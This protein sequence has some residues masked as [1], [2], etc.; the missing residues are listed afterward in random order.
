M[1]ANWFTL[2]A[3]TPDNDNASNDGTALRQQLELTGLSYADWELEA[4]ALR[5]AADGS[6]AGGFIDG[7]HL[8]R[9]GELIMLIEAELAMLDEV[10]ARATGETASQLDGVRSRLK[11]LAA[12]ILEASRKMHGLT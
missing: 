4:A 9:S 7:Q 12:S 1:P 6:A 2:L 8:V 5:R 10:G 11:A 3:M